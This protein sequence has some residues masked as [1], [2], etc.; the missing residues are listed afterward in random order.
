MESSGVQNNENL[1][2]ESKYQ[3]GF[4]QFYKPKDGYGFVVS[5]DNKETFCFSINR[6]KEAAIPEVGRYVCFIADSR[7]AAANRKRSIQTLWYDPERVHESRLSDEERKAKPK[8]DDPRV[9]CPHCG[10]L[11]VPRLSM[12]NGRTR[13]SFC[14]YCGG[15]LR[16]FSNCFIATA[17]YG[18]PL[19][20]EV[21]AL[22]RFRDE[23]LLPYTYGRLMVKIYYA[24]SPTIAKRLDKTTFTARVIRSILNWLA[25]KFG[26]S[27]LPN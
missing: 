6:F 10:K 5:E 13:V 15:E 21:I 27:D 25:E 23:C 26:A 14:P 19:A 4:I 9:K 7:P 2:W 16:R 17:V 11:V 18:D 3:R 1:K 24:V 22:R 12:Y 8:A 20:E